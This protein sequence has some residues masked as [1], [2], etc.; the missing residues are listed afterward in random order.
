MHTVPVRRRLVPSLFCVVAVAGFAWLAVTFDARLDDLAATGPAGP[1]EF[2]DEPSTTDEPDSPPSTAPTADTDVEADAATIDGPGGSGADDGSDPAGPTELDDEPSQRIGSAVADVDLW[3]DPASSGQP[4]SALGAVDGLLTFRGNPTRTFYGRGP[5]PTDPEVVWTFTIGC[6]ISAVGG[7]AREWCG[8][9]WTGQ[10]VLFPSPRGDDTWLAFGGY[11][12][13][14]NFL[15]PVTGEPVTSPYPTGD[16]IKGTVTVDPDGYPLLYTGSRDDYFHVVALDRDVPTQLWSLWAYEVEPTLWNNDW[17]SSALVIDDYLLVGGE[18][19]RFYVVKLNRSIDADGRVA[20]DPAI[21]FT[22]AGWDR[23]LLTALG[24]D[25]VSIENSVAVSGDTVYFTNSGGLVQ[26]WSLAGLTEGVPPRRVF[27]YWTGDDTDASI[28]IDDEGM[29]YLGS[30]YERGNERSQEVGQIVKLDPSRP[31]DPLVWS[32]EARSGVG[33][34]VWA[35]P[36][37]WADLVIVATNEGQV[38]GLDRAT[39]ATR[40]TLEL[41]GPLWSSPT[42]VD[43]VLIQADCAGHVHAYDLAAGDEPV[44]R[45]SV[46]LDDSCIESTPA[47]WDGRIYVGTRSGTFYAIG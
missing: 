31:D 1:T 28:V 34:G 26:G 35:T 16:I 10:P 22:T 40:W 36:A 24:D 44:P 27:R 3:V 32:R 21:E 2:D 18:N 42:V 25:Q 46:R 14:V 4:W 33:S 17:D 41:P 13:A 38:L 20:V 7:E 47:V 11:D 15:D 30:E 39:G 9:G 29:L 8:S 12:R 43:G 23:E 6:S 5:V 37:L 45:W 19:A